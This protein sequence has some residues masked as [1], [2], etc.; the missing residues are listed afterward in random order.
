M[1]IMRTS[2]ATGFTIVELL[3]V[4]VIIAILAAITVVAFNGIQSRAQLS[5]LSSE[6]NSITKKVE[7]FNAEFSTYPTAINDCPTPAAANICLTPPSDETYT[8]RADP[9]GSVTLPGG[10]NTKNDIPSYDLFIYG[11]KS[12]AYS[13]SAERTSASSNEFMQY[14]DLA[15]FIDTY[16]IRKYRLSFDIKSASIA[17]K[18]TVRVYFQNGSGARYGGLNPDVNVTTSYQHYDIEFTPSLNNASI[19]A[20]IL[21][22]YGTYSTGN[23]PTVRN[24]KLTLAQ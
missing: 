8:Y 20:S 19:T 14:V 9:K 1:S 10:V 16:G 12:G 23:I 2:R 13:S 7:L 22:F 3:I 21:A 11:T 6:T 4:V 15:P 18:S 24:V 5:R 17:S